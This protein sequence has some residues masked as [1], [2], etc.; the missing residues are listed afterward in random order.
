MLVTFRQFQLWNNNKK[1]YFSWCAGYIEHQ[2]PHIYISYMFLPRGL[3]KHFT[4]SS[5]FPSRKQ[6]WS[7]KKHGQ[8]RASVALYKMYA[9]VTTGSFR[10]NSNINDRHI[11]QSTYNLCENVLQRAELSS[12]LPFLPSGTGISWSMQPLQA[13][14]ALLDPLLFSRFN[15]LIHFRPHLCASESPQHGGIST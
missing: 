1:K 14:T 7:L 8:P 12:L 3:V 6:W 15:W 9:I 5:L 2:A 10:M 4:I 13:M 11:K